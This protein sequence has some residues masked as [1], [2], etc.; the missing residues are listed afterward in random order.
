MVGAQERILWNPALSVPARTF[1]FADTEIARMK[2]AVET[3]GNY[4]AAPDRRWLEP[5][6]EALFPADPGK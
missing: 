2:A 4:G 1:E 3:W 6:I 5:L